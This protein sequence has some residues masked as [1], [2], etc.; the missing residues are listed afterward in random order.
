GVVTVNGI[1]WGAS[2]YAVNTQVSAYPDRNNS[3]GK[4]RLTEITDG[5]SNTILYAEKYARCTSSSLGLEGGNFWAYCANGRIDFPPAMGLALKLYHP[6]FG[7]GPY[8]SG[9]ESI[10]QVQPTPYLGKCDPRRAST[11]HSGGMSVCLADGAVRTLGPNMS[12]KTWW[13]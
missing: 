13:A 1:C 3:Q 2:S 6:G 10:F 4:R 7:G 12:P 9:P 11:A 8:T 5:T